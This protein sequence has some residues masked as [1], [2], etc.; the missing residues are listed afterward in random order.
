MAYRFLL[1]SSWVNSER[2]FD[3]AHDPVVAEAGT[4]HEV[5]FVEGHAGGCMYRELWWRRLFKM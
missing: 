4:L 2:A 5:W 1:V 3:R